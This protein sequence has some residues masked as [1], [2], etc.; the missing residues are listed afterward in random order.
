MRPDR[1]TEVYNTKEGL[2]AREVSRALLADD[3]GRI[4]VG[5]RFGLYQLVPD[6]APNRPAVAR[7]YTAKDG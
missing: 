7:V 1:V 2:P 5:T 4:W 6:P 3:S